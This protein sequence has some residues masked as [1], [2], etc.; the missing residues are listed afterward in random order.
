MMWSNVV[1][2]YDPTIGVNYDPSDLRVAFSKRDIYSYQ[3]EFRIAILTKVLDPKPL[4]LDIGRID[5]IAFALETAS[6][7]SILWRFNNNIA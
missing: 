2:Y 3:K 5:D 6:L 1:E 7:P 4:T